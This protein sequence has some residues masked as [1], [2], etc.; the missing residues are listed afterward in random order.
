MGKLTEDDTVTLMT[1]DYPVPQCLLLGNKGV[2]GWVGDS[3]HLCNPP[4]CSAQ[5]RQEESC[6][7]TQSMSQ[8][9]EGPER[10]RGTDRRNNV[11]GKK[12]EHRQRPEHVNLSQTGAEDNLASRQLC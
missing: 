4:L 9:R 11:A 7:W 12:E 2:Q 1:L 5:G 8:A 6:S 10:N 3:T